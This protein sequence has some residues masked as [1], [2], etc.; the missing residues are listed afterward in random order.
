M[1]AMKKTGEGGVVMKAIDENGLDKIIVPKFK[2]FNKIIEWTSEHSDAPLKLILKKGIIEYQE[3][4][5]STYFEDMGNNLVKLIVLANENMSKLSIKLPICSFVY[6]LVTGE[7][8]NIEYGSDNP[9]L[10]LT[11]AFDGTIQKTINKFVTLM[12]Y[13]TNFTRTVKC[14]RRQ[15]V[16]ATT[17]KSLKKSCKHKVRLVRTIYEIEVETENDLKEL[18]SMCTISK[19]TY[20]KCTHSFEVRGHWRTTKS[21]KSI[22]IKAYTKGKGN[23]Q[24]KIYEI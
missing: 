18:Q 5:L 14:K 22:W 21:G 19:R 10:K 12:R 2:D 16:S 17:S 1:S 7:T 24:G 9:T 6:N 13:A 8:T 15:S 23:E 20:N 4:G 3:E 11:I